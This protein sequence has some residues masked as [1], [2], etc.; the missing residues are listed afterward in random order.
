MFADIVER[1]EGC[2][3]PFQREWDVV[4]E[5]NRIAGEKNT[6]NAVFTGDLSCVPA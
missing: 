4:N 6:Y 2:R 5:V 3:M 1:R